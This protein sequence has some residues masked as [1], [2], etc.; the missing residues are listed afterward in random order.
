MPAKIKSFILI[1]TWVTNVEA[2]Y[3]IQKWAKDKNLSVNTLFNVFLQSLAFCLKNYTTADERGNIC[4]ELNFGK[5]TVVS[6]RNRT[7][8][9]TGPWIYR[10]RLVDL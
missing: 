7:K 9:G 2:W 5:L 10:K 4:V 6:P 8:T 1:Q 3:A